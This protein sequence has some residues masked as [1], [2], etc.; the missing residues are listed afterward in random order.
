MQPWLGFSVRGFE[1]NSKYLCGRSL[2]ERSA[3]HW[4]DAEAKKESSHMVEHANTAHRGE[5]GVPDFKFKIVQSFKTCLERQIAE[6]VRIQKRGMVL[7]RRGEYNRCNITRLVL[8]NK[9]EQQK[10][11]EAWEEIVDPEGGYDEDLTVLRGSRKTKLGEGRGPKNSKKLKLDNEQ[12]AVWGEEV[13]TETK[14]ILEFLGSGISEPKNSNRSQKSLKQSRLVTLGGVEW[15]AH[16]LLRELA[17]ES[18]DIGELIVDVSPLAR[19]KSTW[20]Q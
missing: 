4:A 1:G 6:A 16:Q 18:V 9:W 11:A 2:F 13:G 14:A 19:K 8:D 10:W 15:L 12:G 17:S 5:E 3:E 7:N 20:Y